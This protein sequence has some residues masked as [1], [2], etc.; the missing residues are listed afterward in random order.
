M[1]LLFSL[2]YSIPMEISSTGIEKNEYI[3]SPDIAEGSNTA[4][5]YF[6]LKLRNAHKCKR[7]PFLE[8]GFGDL[9]DI[10]M[11]CVFNSSFAL[12]GFWQ[13]N[14]EVAG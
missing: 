8:I 10:K 5:T 2:D 4:L 13:I 1:H 12:D 3:G 6:C 11:F 14:V 7:P 9:E